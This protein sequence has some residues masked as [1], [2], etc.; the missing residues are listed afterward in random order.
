[1]V[2]RRTACELGSF[3]YIEEFHLVTAKLCP[4]EVIFSFI[5]FKITEFLFIYKNFIYKTELIG[6]HRFF[7]LLK[8]TKIDVCMG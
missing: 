5:Q 1:M 4:E 3:M 6:Y 2:E 8:M 7:F